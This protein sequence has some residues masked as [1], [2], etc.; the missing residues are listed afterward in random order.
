MNPFPFVRFGVLSVAFGLATAGAQAQA[1]PDW[2]LN[3]ALQ[4]TDASTAW[5]P[6]RYATTAGGPLDLRQCN[7]VPGYGWMTAAP[8]FTLTYDA[9]DRGFDLDFRVEAPC[10]TVL[11]INDATADWHFNDDEDNSLNPRLRLGGARSGVY[12]IWV[13]TY[14]SATCAATL[15]VETFP[16]AT[17]TETQ[18]DA[19]QAAAAP[20]CP[21]WSIGGAE[22]N[23]SAGAADTRDVVAGGSINLFERASACGITGHGHV[24]PGPDFTLYYDAPNADAELQIAAT[25]DCD[26]L[27]LVNDLNAAWLFND[28]HDGLD[29]MISIPA[30]ATG[31]YDIWVGTYGEALC[32]ASMTVTSIAPAPPPLSK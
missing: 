20:A 28:D 16:A 4:T 24:A 27:L 29:P 21:D 10:D 22:M 30:A 1:C 11:L 2:Q 13:G 26:T 5:A 23:L 7:T 32:R 8:S 3:G 25:G 14:D 12:D 19:G 15:V 17:G 6:Q 18:T 9:Q 31:R